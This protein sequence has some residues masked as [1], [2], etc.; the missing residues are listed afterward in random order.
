NR[1]TGSLC[2]EPVPNSGSSLSGVANR[3]VRLE[4]FWT[5][6]AGQLNLEQRSSNNPGRLNFFQYRC[7]LVAKLPRTWCRKDGVHQVQAPWAR[8]GSGF[9]LLMEALMML[10]SAQ[11]PVD[12]MANLLKEHDTRLWRVLMHYVEQ[13]HAE[14]RTGQ[15]AIE[16]FRRDGS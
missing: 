16:C 9:T 4:E 8:E 1:G 13:E 14:K 10:Q 15:G 11:M 2:G 5:C 7:E 6:R 3:L 12:A